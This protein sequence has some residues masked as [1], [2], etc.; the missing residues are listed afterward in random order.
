MLHA[1][2]FLYVLEVSTCT[3][4][5]HFAHLHFQ[6]PSPRSLSH[7]F[8][9]FLFGTFLQRQQKKWKQNQY[10]MNLQKHIGS[11]QTNPLT[12]YFLNSGKMNRPVR[13]FVHFSCYSFKFL[14]RQIHFQYYIKSFTQFNKRQRSTSIRIKHLKDH[15]NK[16]DKK[17]ENQIVRHQT[18]L[19]SAHSLKHLH[20]L[21]K[22]I[23]SDCTITAFAAL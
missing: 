22:F 4:M 13:I 10:T 17:T 20:C 16:S 23:V 6:K 3:T 5:L 8:L 14:L 12:K 19:N 9:P 1:C 18:R 2:I 15:K 7:D 11:T 21:F